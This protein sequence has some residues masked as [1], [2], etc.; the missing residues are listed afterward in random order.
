M[1]DIGDMIRTLKSSKNKNAD[2]LVKELVSG[3]SEVATQKPGT[4]NFSG[5]SF[6]PSKY[7]PA[8]MK[9]GGSVSSASKR[10]DGCA[11]RGKTKCKM[12]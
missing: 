10:A 7:K 11:Q 5:Y 4:T 6:D 1:R 9:K 12:V 2:E 3:A 8:N